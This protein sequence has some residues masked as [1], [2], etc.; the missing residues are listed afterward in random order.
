VQISLTLE[1]CNGDLSFALSEISSSSNPLAI[2]CNGDSG[3]PVFANNVQV[4]IVSFG[5]GGCAA[6]RYQDVYVNVA[7]YSDWIQAYVDGENCQPSS[8]SNVEA[9]DVVTDTNN[10][11]DDVSDLDVLLD[12]FVT[13]YETVQY[14]LGSVN[15][16]DGGDGN[17]NKGGDNGGKR[18]TLRDILWGYD[19][20]DGPEPGFVGSATNLFKKLTESKE[21]FEGKTEAIAKAL[22]LDDK[23]DEV[24]A[25]GGGQ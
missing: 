1:V 24:A 11:E 23:L 8:G 12:C 17:D 19:G 22:G 25:N 18:T 15:T 10:D 5:Y 21:T 20:I 6:D 14:L 9:G 7:A 13:V 3:G 16:N 4:G 2:D